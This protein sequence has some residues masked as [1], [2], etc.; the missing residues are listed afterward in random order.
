MGAY[1]GPHFGPGSSGH[2]K[3]ETV[4]VHH[5][6]TCFGAFINGSPENEHKISL[7]K[8]KSQPMMILEATAKSVPVIAHDVGLSPSSQSSFWTHFLLPLLT[9]L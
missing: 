6:G 8:S 1:Q 5:Y 9:L 2:Q 3:C 4:N 7:L